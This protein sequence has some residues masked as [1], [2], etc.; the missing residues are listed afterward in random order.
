LEVEAKML[1]LDVR[2][3]L[4]RTEVKEQ[5]KKHPQSRVIN[6]LELLNGQARV[7]VAIINSA[8]HGYEIKSASD[9]LQRLNDQQLAYRKVFERMTLVAD[10]KHVEKAVKKVP[11]NWGLIAVGVKEGKPYADEIWPARKNPDV[12]KLALAQLLW[13]DEAMELLEYFE[14]LA[15]YRRARRKMLWQTIAKS[16]TYDQIQAFV[17]YKLK[18]R[19]NW[20]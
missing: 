11:A 19:K 3:L 14:L 18:A 1:E 7:D 13:R 2:R 10:E 4:Y 5:L 9:N 12:E 20:R 16:L 17:C 6:E 15:G 8:L